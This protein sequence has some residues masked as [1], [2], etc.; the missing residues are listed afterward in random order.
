MVF[1]TPVILQNRDSIL[2]EGR[3]TGVEGRKK[4]P[5]TPVSSQTK[6]APLRLRRDP[7]R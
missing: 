5:V 2:K 7:S 4:K 6:D 3:N 1:H